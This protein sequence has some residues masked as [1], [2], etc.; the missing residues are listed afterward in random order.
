MEIYRA[1]TPNK[2]IVGDPL[3]FQQ[4]KGEK[5]ASLIV[6]ITPPKHFDA[7]IVLEEFPCDELPEL[8]LKTMSIYLAPAATMDV[9]LRGMMYES[10]IVTEK[11]IG[12]DSAAYRIRVGDREEIFNTGGD[13]YWGSHTEF[14]R[15]I[16][17]KK[18]QDATITTVYMPDDM[19]MDDVRGYNA[20]FLKYLT[21][22]FTE[23][24]RNRRYKYRLF[25]AVISPE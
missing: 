5:L 9:Y 24:E 17:G 8:M 16:G 22:T 13:G 3:Y 20:L 15:S 23:R 7:R 12:V 25:G 21:N 19:S 4:Y 18:V 11:G 1:D 14:N 2:L 6:D 10:Q